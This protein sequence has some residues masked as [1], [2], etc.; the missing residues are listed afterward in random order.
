MAEYYYIGQTG[1]R[2]VFVGEIVSAYKLF[3]KPEG[4]VLFERH[5]WED[6]FRMDFQ[7]H[8]T[9]TEVFGGAVSC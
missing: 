4:K 8:G 3:R 6:N 1:R 9:R 7:E 5:I 2:I